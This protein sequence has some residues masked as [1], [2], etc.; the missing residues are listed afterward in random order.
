MLSE[1]QQKWNLSNI[2]LWLANTV[3]QLK[4]T[5]AVDRVMVP[6]EDTYG[7]HPDDLTLLIHTAFGAGADGICIC[8]TCSRGK[9]PQYTENLIRFIGQTIAPEFPDKTWE[10]HTHNML[11][12]GVS[13]AITAVNEGLISVVHGTFGGVGDLGGNMPL[14]QFVTRAA[15]SGLLSVHTDALDGLPDLV[16]QVLAARN[17]SPSDKLFG[18]IYAP[19]ARFVPTGVHASAFKRLEEIGLNMR[20]VFEHVYFPIAP[21]ELGLDIRLDI[22]TPVSGKHN[23][24]ALAKRL[25][26]DHQL[27]DGITT[28]ILT[29]AREKGEPLTNTEF[30]QHF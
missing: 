1:G 6:L 27:T 18:D 10:L 23:V 20:W 19:A 12:K 30:L 25:G 28:S 17:I 11:G 7:A 13:N 24:L 9:T 4:K 16:K 5:A 26:L 21:S 14:E 29:H 15:S 22:V 2:T 8:D 3:E